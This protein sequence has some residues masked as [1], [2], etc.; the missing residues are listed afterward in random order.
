MP[1]L[2]AAKRW[3]DGVVGRLEVGA[4]A[5]SFVLLG[6]RVDAFWAASGETWA[7]GPRATF[8]EYQVSW[9]IDGASN[10]VSRG[11]LWEP[12]EDAYRHFSNAWEA[13]YPYVLGL[14]YKQGTNLFLNGA[15]VVRLPY[16]VRIADASTAD[17]TLS[18]RVDEDVA[19]RAAG[20]TVH[21]NY[22]T[23]SDQTVPSTVDKVVDGPGMIELRLS[24]PTVQWSVTL[25]STDGIRRDF[26]EQEETAPRA[27]VAVPYPSLGSILGRDRRRDVGRTYE[28]SASGVPPTSDDTSIEPAGDLSAATD[29]PPDFSRI[30]NADSTDLLAQR[31]QEAVLCLQ[32]GASLSAIAMM[33]SLLEGALLQMAMR[34]PG[35]ANR[36]SAAP[37]DGGKPRPW[38]QWRL[39]DLIN[40]AAQAHW[41]TVDLQDFSVILRDYRNLLHPWVSR[42]K[43][44][45]PTADSAAICWEIT[46]RVVDQL[47]AFE[48]SAGELR[49]VK[50]PSHKL[51]SLPK[52]TAMKPGSKSLSDYVREQRR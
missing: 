6:D 28:E 8:P 52:R 21:V 17:A 4:E 25:I 26:R 7:H 42:T 43:A 34:R 33:G 2:E 23:R 12:L 20:H 36:T 48:A 15:A 41:I 29:V 18:V 47:F 30:A 31:W 35:E 37:K 51:A 22:R 44:F 45:H 38:K 49:Q 1:A 13:I 9:I 39:T 16:P 5:L 14:P 24:G 3:S 50:S 10:L 32:A 40:V 46:R 19:D 11:D 27:T